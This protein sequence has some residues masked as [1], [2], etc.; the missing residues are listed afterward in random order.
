MQIID[1]VHGAIEITENEQP[2]LD[3][4]AFQRLRKIKQLSNVHLAFPSAVHTRFAH[5]L[6]VMHVATR[7]F[8]TLI[9]TRKD[10]KTSGS[11]FKH[12]RNTVRLAGMLHD[13]GHGPYSHQFETFLKNKFKYDDLHLFHVPKSSL[14]TD[15][16]GGKLGHE[17]FSF[18]LIHQV[19][20]DVNH[21]IK[22]R[23]IC[24]LLD[25][26]FSI[27]ETFKRSIESVTK[28]KASSESFVEVLRS[29]LSSEIDA[30]RI[31]Y[32]QRDSL[33]CGAKI[34]VLDFEHLIGSIKLSIR[35]EN[36][37]IDLQSN[38]LSTVEQI[39]LARKAMFEQVY[40]HR[41]NVIFGDVLTQVLNGIG[42]GSEIED[43]VT[44]PEY[45]VSFTDESLNQIILEQAS[46]KSD[47]NMRHLCRIFA[48]RSEPKRCT[49]LLLGGEGE[50]V[51]IESALVQSREGPHNV[52]ELPAKT[53]T[54]LKRKG[55]DGNVI[56]K[57]DTVIY[58]EERPWSAYRPLNEVSSL[59]KSNYGLRK[60]VAY[61]AVED[62][63]STAFRR[64][65][66]KAFEKLRKAA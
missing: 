37:F 47:T 30:D 55:S 28:K 1:P 12:I 14:I 21:Q 7:L 17:V 13:L 36:F 33:F 19:C 65:V 15:L 34:G 27:S 29:I 35:D 18:G 63:F 38:A 59:L 60:R 32:L 20:R 26:R 41:T 54:D 5:S 50:R 10:L 42:L 23:D 22:P 48:T 56:G 58:V 24:A 6:G 64:R 53:L 44:N 49:D 8:D 40:C 3:H 16:A 61:L 66:N 11:S 57:E 9:R 62:I 51:A 39:L 45:F 52:I 43:A 4:P 46:Q 31:D 2:F 25:R